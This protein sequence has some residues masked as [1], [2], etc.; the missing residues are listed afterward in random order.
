MGFQKRFLHPPRFLTNYLYSTGEPEPFVKPTGIREESICWLSGKAASALCPHVT[1]ELVLPASDEPAPCDLSHEPDQNYYL[2]SQYAQWIHHLEMQQGRGRFPLIGPEA[3]FS[4]SASTY[5]D[6]SSMR[7]NNPAKTSA[8]EIVS[9]HDSDRFILSP[10]TSGSI[11]FRAVPNPLWTMSSG[12]WTELKLP[13]LP[14]PM[15]SFGGLSA[16]STRF[17]RLPRAGRARK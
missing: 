8:I 3:A 13:G 4:G 1:K 9:P 16:V 17:M 6:P 11:L 7:P 10:H 5:I 15:N 14:H 12:F 2:G